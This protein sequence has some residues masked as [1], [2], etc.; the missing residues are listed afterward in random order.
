MTTDTATRLA[1]LPRVNLLPPEI[2]E[3][4]RLQLVQAAAVVLVIAAVGGVGFLYTNGRESVASAKKSLDTATSQNSALTRQLATFSNV[5]G[6]AA[7]LAAS[8][9]LLTQATASEVS[10][11]N[12]LADLSTLLPTTT[13]LTSL[14]VNESVQPGTLVAPAQAPA[15]IGTLSVQ[16]F[17]LKYP[18]LADWLDSVAKESG[19]SN[20]YFSTAT[21]QFIGPTKVVTFQG[22]STV[23]AS[24]LDGRCA[25]AGSC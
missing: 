15:A 11:S 14:T 9:A 20:V 17:A 6:T 7:Q 19:L 10:W 5:K 4:R 8:Q 24:A 22:S 12:F 2:H 16:G 1:A 21:E 23:T 18:N 3:R 13:W 25:S